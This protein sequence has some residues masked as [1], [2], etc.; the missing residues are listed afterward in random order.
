MLDWAAVYWMDLNGPKQG[1]TNSTGARNSTKHSSFFDGNETRAHRVQSELALAQSV[2]SGYSL[3]G[4]D[5]SV[6]HDVM[7]V[8]INNT[9]SYASEYLHHVKPVSGVKSS[10]KPVSDVKPDAK[11][12]KNTDIGNVD[13]NAENTGRRG[14]QHRKLLLNY[15]SK[16][17]TQLYSTL[18]AHG[19]LNAQ[20]ALSGWL[21]DGWL[22][23]PYGWPPKYTYL[24]GNMEYTCAA[25]VE[26]YDE[27]S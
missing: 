19:E 9:Q 26:I 21:A 24:S 20:N 11:N 7:L 14:S 27:V 13:T 4:V 23:G 3:F 12:T 1:R 18:V 8:A 10:T 6:L 16:D 25:G 22:G 17:P 15:T 5:P 2:I